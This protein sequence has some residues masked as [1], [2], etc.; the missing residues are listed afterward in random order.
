M[1]VLAVPSLSMFLVYIDH[2]RWRKKT[3]I[4]VF[5]QPQWIT[6]SV[7]SDWLSLDW[8]EAYVPPTTIWN[9]CPIFRQFFIYISLV[10]ER[11][12]SK[13]VR[14]CSQNYSAKK[15]SQKKSVL[16]FSGWTRFYFKYYQKIA[17]LFAPKTAS[18]N[19]F[20]FFWVRNCFT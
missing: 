1:M 20:N 12:F 19:W 4:I 9:D 14:H 11:C 7:F 18:C 8:S 15:F 16:Q 6:Q 5:F 13:K 3:G 2:V 17:V 10:T